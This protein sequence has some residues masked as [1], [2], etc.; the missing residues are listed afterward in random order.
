[1]GC[2]QFSKKMVRAQVGPME[3]IEV[4]D[5]Y[6]ILTNVGNNGAML[7][8]GKDFSPALKIALL[9]VLPMLVLLAMLLR[10]LGNDQLGT[11]TIMA[12]ACVIGGG[13]GNLVDRIFQGYVTDF[14]QIRLGPIKTGIFNLADVS[15][16]LG[17]LFI[18]MLAIKQK[19]I[20]F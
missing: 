7:G 12:F 17:V 4:L 6:L 13:M 5:E 16:T 8:F 19:K 20:P 14:F 10:I 15:V 9:Q 3:Y 2:D 11:F 18:I 1:M